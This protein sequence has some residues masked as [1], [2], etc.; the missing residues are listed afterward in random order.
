MANSQLIE[1]FES[2]SRRSVVIVS[3][4]HKNSFVDCIKFS[5][6]DKRFIVLAHRKAFVSQKS[7]GTY[8]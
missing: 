8:L 3:S 4:C 5:G 1:V 7:K 2:L 6:F